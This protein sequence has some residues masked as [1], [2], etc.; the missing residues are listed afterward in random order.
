MKSLNSLIYKPRLLSL[1]LALLFVFT[2]SCSDDENPGTE[3]PPENALVNATLV[4]SAS[5]AQ[6]K[7]VAQLAG[8][9]I[10][11]SEFVNDVDIYKVSYNTVYKGEGIVASGLISLP[12]TG[13]AVPMISYQHGTITRDTDAPSN[14]AVNKPEALIASALSSSGFIAVIPDYLGFGSSATILHPYFVEDLTASAVVDMLKAAEELAGEKNITFNS[15][16]FLAGYSEGGYATMATHKALEENPLEGFDLVASF[17]GAGAYDLAGLQ[18]TLLQAETYDDPYYL[19][20]LV[21]GYQL[22]YDL[23]NFLTD[24]FQEPYAS[25]IPGLF[26]HQKGPGEIDEA[27]TTNIQ[28]LIQPNLAADITSNPSYAYIAQAFE[29]NTLTD[30]TPTRKMYMYHGLSDKTVPYENSVNTYNG[31]LARGASDDV[32]SLTPLPG[33][34][35]SAVTPYIADFLAKLRSL[36]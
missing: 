1:A 20:Y 4:F 34:H 6:A 27:L 12:K 24:F 29:E 14:F 31:L 30:W 10:D 23:P 13:E 26:D 16:L 9:N 8:L 15:K 7:L 18:S 28:D 11:I 32:I 2:I 33:D 3:A 36:R 25:R 5:S 35:I 22:V 17:P 19:A 21:T